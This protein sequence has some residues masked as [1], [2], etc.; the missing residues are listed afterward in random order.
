MGFTESTGKSFF[1]FENPKKKKKGHFVQVRN[2]DPQV[3]WLKALCQT[4]YLP[5]PQREQRGA[6]EE[7]SEQTAK[8]PSN[9]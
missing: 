7:L 2:I 8:H 3:K 6:S 5:A 4:L 1:F 9:N